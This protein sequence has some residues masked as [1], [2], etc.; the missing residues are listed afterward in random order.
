VDKNS[1][2]DIIDWKIKEKVLENKRKSEHTSM[3]TF[4]G[5]GNRK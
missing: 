4:Y 1:V 2:R 3:S 5:V